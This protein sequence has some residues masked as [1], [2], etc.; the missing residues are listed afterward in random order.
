MGV[1]NAC[2]AA[3][4]AKRKPVGAKIY[5]SLKGISTMGELAYRVVDAISVGY[6]VS[7]LVCIC[8]LASLTRFMQ[9]MGLDVWQ[10]VRD[11]S[12]RQIYRRYETDYFEVVLVETLAGT[13]QA[14]Y[15]PHYA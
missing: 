15:T 13:E 8:D 9:T 7:K 6:T 10:H 5:C 1:F 2:G 4:K 12:L 14:P 11:R 3:C